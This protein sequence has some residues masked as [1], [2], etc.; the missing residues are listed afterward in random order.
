MSPLSPRAERGRPAALVDPK[1][2]T[3][4]ERD[5]LRRIQMWRHYRVPGGY[6]MGGDPKRCTLAM[7]QRLYTLGLVRFERTA[8][9]IMIAPTGNG[10]L[11][12]AIMDERARQARS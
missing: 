3:A 8:G 11:T 7:A 12:V 6:K 1:E 2:L 9:R 4:A 10:N 5:W